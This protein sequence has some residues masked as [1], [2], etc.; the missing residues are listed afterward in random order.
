MRNVNFVFGHSPEVGGQVLCMEPFCAK[1]TMDTFQMSP[2]LIHSLFS[3]GLK[4][5]SD[6]DSQTQAV[7]MGQRKRM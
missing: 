1:A 3:Q 6:S 4:P 2:Q 7:F 5:P